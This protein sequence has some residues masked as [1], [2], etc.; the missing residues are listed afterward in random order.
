MLAERENRLQ[1]FHRALTHEMRNRVGVTLGAAQVLEQPGLDERERSE[2][3]RVI[4]R[5]AEGMR[6][7]LENLLEL[8]HAHASPRQQRHVR[9]PAVAAE[10]ARQ[11]REAAD[12]A[13]VA[14][15]LAPTLPDVEV[16]AA[17]V[18]LVLANYLS[19][20]I[21][22][23][24]PDAGERWVEV[25]G[26]G[27]SDGAADDDAGQVVIEVEDNG[28]GVPKAQRSQLFER[29]FRAHE[30]TLPAIEGTGL[31][32]SVVRDTVG[33]LGGRAW[34]EFPDAGGAIFAFTLPCRRATDL[35]TGEQ[36][37]DATGP[38]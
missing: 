18:E 26:R 14:V 6:A 28:R 8:S 10:A 17:A 24:D 23:S 33:A 31:G 4:A 20:A 29:F 34:A 21:K 27:P 12:R 16:N 7:M 15:R 3:T 19:N 9:L 25:R 38:L 1:G 37:T 5:N 32:L 2:L 11:L 13:G 35:A 36:P 30:G 22:Y